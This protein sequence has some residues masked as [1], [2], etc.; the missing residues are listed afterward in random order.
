MISIEKGVEYHVFFEFSTI[1]VKINM[2]SGN[3]LN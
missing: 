3:S 2:L 1:G